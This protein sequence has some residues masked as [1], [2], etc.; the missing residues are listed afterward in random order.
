MSGPSDCREIEFPVI[1]NPAGNIAVIEGPDSVPFPIAR[2]YYLYSVPEGAER[3]GHAHRRLRQILIAV[4]GAFDVVLNDGS[5]RRSVRLDSPH[6]GL[7]V[8]NMV[9]RELVNFAAGSVCLVIASERYDESD[10]IRDFDEFARLQ[11]S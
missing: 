2:V 10:Y 7:Y 5:D 8:P 1:P 11:A 3:G 9:W 4:A 6:R